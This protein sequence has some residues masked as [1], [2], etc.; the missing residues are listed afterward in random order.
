MQQRN[1]N[2]LNCPTHVFENQNRAILSIHTPCEAYIWQSLSQ[3]GSSCGRTCPLFY[4]T[5]LYGVHATGCQPLINSSN[6]KSNGATSA[7]VPKL[8]ITLCYRSCSSF[9]GIRRWLDMCK[10]EWLP[11]LTGIFNHFD[12]LKH[13]FC[14]ITLRLFFQ[15]KIFFVICMASNICI[16]ELD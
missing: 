10:S 3:C 1:F 7:T 5:N 8:F 4:I 13:F 2:I 6:N 15:E 14:D 12:I 9:Y 11:L 16:W